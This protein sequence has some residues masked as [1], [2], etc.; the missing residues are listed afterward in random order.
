MREEWTAVRDTLI[1]TGEE[2]AELVA[3]A[4]PGKPATRDWSVAETAAHTA[5][6]AWLDGYLLRGEPLPLPGM[7]EAVERA[8][9]D[10]ISDLN[11]VWLAH[12]TE[13]DP[14]ALATRLRG[15]L[16]ATLRAADAH[17]DPAELVPWLGGS[18]VPVIGVLA[19][20]LNELQIHGWDIARATGRPWSIPPEEAAIFFDRFLLGV[21]RG[22]TGRLLA[23]PPGGPPERRI[24]VGFRSRH[25]AP[26][27]MVL[28]RERVWL[29]DPDRP[30]DIVIDFDPATL[31][32]MLF[33]R[34]SKARAVLSRKIS[35]RGRRPWLLPAFLRTVR[36]PS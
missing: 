10:T 18:R 6:A 24:A 9:V 30:A 19:H 15:E 11:E 5:D 32:L 7:A 8:T 33:G 34:V 13:R 16:A 12:F 1:R 22:G 4:D 31:N 21:T 29:E 26:V 17:A 35:I 27:N 3:A 20:L 28:Q 23:D 2:F 14:A 25:T 36:L